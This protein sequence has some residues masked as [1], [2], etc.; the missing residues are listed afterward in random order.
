MV[1]PLRE[2]GIS[3]GVGSGNKVMELGGVKGWWKIVYV[4]TDKEGEFHVLVAY[5]FFWMVWPALKQRK[6]TGVVGGDIAAGVEG[7][8]ERGDCVS[9]L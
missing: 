1:R 4:G 9:S 7:G 3:T 5:M 2:Q 6:S 8:E